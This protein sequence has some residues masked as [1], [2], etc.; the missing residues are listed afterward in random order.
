[1]AIAPPL[2]AALYEKVLPVTTTL[3][4]LA[5][6]PPL[7]TAVFDVTQHCRSVRF[8]QFAIPPPSPMLALPLVIVSPEIDAVTPTSTWNTRLTLLPLTVTPAVGPVIVIVAVPVV[9]RNSSWAPPSVIVCAVAKT[10]ASKIMAWFPPL[11]FAWAIASRRSV[12]PATGVSV[13]LFTTIDADSRMRSSN[14]TM[15]GASDT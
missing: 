12:R 2:S 13:G 10:I 4:K 14:D 1:M 3:P 15:A 6:P 11:V 5:R 8:P 7:P 9:S